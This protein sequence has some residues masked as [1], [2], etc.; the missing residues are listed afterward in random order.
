MAHSAGSGDK[1][2]RGARSAI[3]T[4]RD[5]VSV[6]QKKWDEMFSDF[7]PKA[8]QEKKDETAGTGKKEISRT[9]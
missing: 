6:S 3:Y 5:E 2:A 8:F 9:R 4:V 7:D 1:L